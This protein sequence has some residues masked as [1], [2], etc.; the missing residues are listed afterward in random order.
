MVNSPSSAQ[1]ASDVQEQSA[2]VPL[3]GAALKPSEGFRQR[4]QK[5][6]VSAG[7]AMAVRVALPE[8]SA[9]AMGSAPTLLF[10]GGGQS[11]LGGNVP[12]MAEAP[13]LHSV[14]PVGPPPPR[15]GAR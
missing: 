3:H 6:C 10:S 7:R 15:G 11:W 5:T 2:L 1:S 4:P 13:G 9:K 12:L 14:P 8:V